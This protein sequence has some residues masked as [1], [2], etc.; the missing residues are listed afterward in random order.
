MKKLNLKKRNCKFFS[1][2]KTPAQKYSTPLYMIVLTRKEQAATRKPIGTLC[3]A[4]SNHKA[5]SSTACCSSSSSTSNSTFPG[6]G[7]E[8]QSSQFFRFFSFLQ[9]SIHGEYFFNN[10]IDWLI[11]WFIWVVIQ[12]TSQKI[13]RSGVRTPY[14]ETWNLQ[15][16]WHSMLWRKRGKAPYDCPLL[17]TVP[18]RVFINQLP[19]SASR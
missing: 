12:V 16:N 6:L 19:L 15:W 11:D 1:F 2:W 17:H 14:V 10:F 5:L 3:E 7:F 8:S 18:Q 9:R 13:A 4:I